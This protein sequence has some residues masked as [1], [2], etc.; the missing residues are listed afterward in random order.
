VGWICF[1]LGIRIEFFG[2]DGCQDFAARQRDGKIKLSR[3]F[4]FSIIG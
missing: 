3:I 1:Q 4:G 2:M